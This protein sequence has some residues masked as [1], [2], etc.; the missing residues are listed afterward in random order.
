MK[1]KTTRN[2]KVCAVDLF[3]GAG[4]LTKGLIQAGIDVKLGVDIDAACEYPYVVNN[5][6]LFIRKPVEDL[7]AWE[8]EAAFKKNSIRLF[9]GCPPCQTFSKYNPKATPDDKRWWLLHHFSRLI[10]QVKPE[11]VTMENVPGIVKH[12][13]FASFVKTLKCAQYEVAY[14][15]VN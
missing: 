10:L 3:C 12:K 6:A 7:E 9:A 8:L 5:S 11:L 2:W 4:G 15:I 1:G 14:I 13:V